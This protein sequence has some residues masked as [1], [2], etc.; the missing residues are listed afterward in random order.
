M[1]YLSRLIL[2][3]AII[4]FF[5]QSALSADSLKIGV[6]DVQSCLEG[7]NEGKRVSEAL[8][9]MQMSLKK[10]YDEKKAELDELQKELD[11]QSLMLSMDAKGDK[12]KEYERKKRELGYFIQDI[13]EELGR[14]K[15][16]AESLVM[17]DLR[18][19]VKK[20]GK[21]GKYDLILEESRGNLVYWS[22]TIDITKKVINE[23]NNKKP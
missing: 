17:K 11:R 15:L 4:L 1:R 13:Q 7:S 14:A 21:E 19:I 12:Q 2:G 10:E 6:Y 3:V 9:K 16:N 22:E 20:I 23:Y 18:E 8:R 5:Q